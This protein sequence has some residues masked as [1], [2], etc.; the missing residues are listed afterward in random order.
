LHV[1]LLSQASQTA[2]AT[3]TAAPDLQDL[4]SFGAGLTTIRHLSQGCNSTKPQ[5][6]DCHFNHG[7]EQIDRRNNSPGNVDNINCSET[8]GASGAQ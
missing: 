5:N 1:S 8:G 7:I 2:K 6:Y 3:D 4:S